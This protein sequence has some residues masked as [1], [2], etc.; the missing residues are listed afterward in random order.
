M[1]A[2]FHF[3]ILNLSHQL[4][5]A[6]W[7]LLLAGLR[8]SYLPLA[9]MSETSTPRV[10]P[11]LLLT[12]NSLP[13]TALYSPQSC[14]ILSYPTLSCPT[15]PFL[16]LPNP[17]NN[18]LSALITP[19]YPYFTITFSILFVSSFQHFHN[20]LEV[21]V[22]R[23]TVHGRRYT[24]SAAC[25]NL[26]ILHSI[27]CSNFILLWTNISY[28]WTP[29]NWFHRCSCIVLNC[30]VSLALNSF[31]LSCNVLY[32]IVLNWMAITIVR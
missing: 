1:C 23:Y 2:I 3:Y 10:L 9:A 18:Q 17:P 12:G 32:C 26:F 24:V 28:L 19:L 5:H 14:P 27:P 6:R 4:L 20:D 8:R 21:P 25:W 11:C 31:I 7:T 29:F 22:T 16:V 13:P 30:I 15:Q